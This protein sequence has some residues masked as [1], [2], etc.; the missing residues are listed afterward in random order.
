MPYPALCWQC[1]LSLGIWLVIFASHVFVVRKSLKENFCS[2]FLQRWESHFCRQ[3]VAG[4]AGAAIVLG[5][6][7]CLWSGK[8]SLASP[9][10]EYVLGQLRWEDRVSLPWLSML[11]KR[12]VGNIAGVGG[13]RYHTHCEWVIACWGG[14][15]AVA[16]QAGM[17]RDRGWPS[18]RKAST[19]GKN[20]PT[21]ETRDGKKCWLWLKLWARPP[22]PGF[23]ICLGL[24]SLCRSE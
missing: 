12:S 4:S 15:M 2:D 22:G 10:P 9:D 13:F 14:R 8:C 16:V 7:L 6:I 18:H 21:L 19:G 5:I 1:Y 20:D 3:G 23:T 24:G 11:L 17:V